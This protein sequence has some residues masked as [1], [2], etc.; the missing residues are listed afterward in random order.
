MGESHHVAPK[1]RWSGSTNV[2][3]NKTVV[4]LRDMLITPSGGLLIG[5]E[6]GYISHRNRGQASWSLPLV[7]LRPPLWEPSVRRPVQSDK[8]HRLESPATAPIEC[9]AA[10]PEFIAFPALLV[11]ENQIV[12]FRDA[13]R[14][15]LQ[16][17]V[18][19]AKL[20]SPT[21]E[22]NTP[23]S[24]IL[25]SKQAEITHRCTYSRPHRALGDEQ[26]VSTLVYG[27][28][29]SWEQLVAAYGGVEVY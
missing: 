1:H 11:D 18:N 6:D 9:L 19:K 16:E 12:N 15:C 20:T 22:Q 27:D 7:S 21:V 4:L 23:L 29:V 26:L 14:S 8:T 2:D 17:L 25:G 10:S 28:H 13:T 24:M 3:R 5:F